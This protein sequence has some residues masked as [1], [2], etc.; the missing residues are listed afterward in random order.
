[1]TGGM[2]GIPR[3]PRMGGSGMKFAITLAL[4]VL[5]AVFYLTV[6]KRSS[7][8]PVPSPIPADVVRLAYPARHG[9]WVDVHRDASQAPAALEDR[10]RWLVKELTQTDSDPSVF[11]PLPET[12]PVRSVYRDG[13][14]LY[15]DFSGDALSCLSGGSADEI[16]ALE[17]LKQTLA[18]NLPDLER[19]QILVDGHPSRTLGAAGEDA[20]HIDILKPISLRPVAEAAQ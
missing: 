10:A 2:E 9:G 11:P 4:I 12:F 20:G 5:L 18:W 1:M 3:S 13:K 15:L 19:V 17:S 8:G 6:F 16:I 7:A 14:L